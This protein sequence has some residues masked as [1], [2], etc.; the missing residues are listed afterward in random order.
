[1]TRTID[2]RIFFLLPD[3]RDH[4]RIEQLVQQEICEA[5]I[6]NEPALVK[7]ILLQ[8]DKS[9]LLIDYNTFPD[10]SGL[11][12]Y[13]REIIGECGDHLLRV[14]I[15]GS[16]SQQDN[17]NPKVLYLSREE[18][19]DNEK[20]KSVVDELNIWGLR[21]YIRFGSHNSR[22]AVFRMKFFQS[23]RTGV[24]HD[25]SASGM[26][27]SFDR[28]DD[29]DVTGNSTIIEIIIHEQI[30]RLEGNFLI[31]RTFKN[32]NM[33]VLVFSSRRGGGNLKKL[34]SIIFKLTRQQV[35]EKI[36]KLA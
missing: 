32:S 31:R 22:I 2:A 16:E 19:D 13:C 33:F 17:R 23:W 21:N 15:V 30:F 36:E 4:K 9:I 29:I 12:E 28:H 26:S 1:M 10:R 24:I 35:L 20:L 7:K 8:Q 6:L 5:F 34:N 3:I 14:C 27:C 25:I 11:E 18:A